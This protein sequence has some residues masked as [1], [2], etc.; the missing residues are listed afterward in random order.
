MYHKQS[1]TIDAPVRRSLLKILF[2]IFLHKYTM[3]YHWIQIVLGIHMLTFITA[4]TC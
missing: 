3:M 1:S 2:L 4:V